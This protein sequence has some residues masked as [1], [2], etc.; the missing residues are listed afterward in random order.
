MAAVGCKEGGILNDH[1]VFMSDSLASAVKKVPIRFEASMPMYVTDDGGLL[2][3]E[4]FV[5]SVAGD[6]E[7]NS[8]RIA[9]IL[10]DGS[11]TF[12]KMPEP[13]WIA[14]GDIPQETIE[15]F[16]PDIQPINNLFKGSDG[17]FYS[18]GISQPRFQ[19]EFLALALTKFDSGLKIVYDYCA[20]FSLDDDHPLPYSWRSARQRTFCHP[21][22]NGRRVAK[23]G[24]LFGYNNCCRWNG[25][26]R[27]S[28]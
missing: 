4:D 21:F 26:K 24:G 16:A 5:S 28:V 7:M 3:V 19:S 9:K 12:M 15:Q 2:L 22:K 8:T 20:V 27:N 13:H 18:L 10:P 11:K 1:N 23:S 25:G 6:Q 17:C 14:N